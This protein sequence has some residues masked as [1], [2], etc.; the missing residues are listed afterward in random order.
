MMTLCIVGRDRAEVDERL[1]SSGGIRGS[2]KQ[3]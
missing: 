2:P 3:A 1:R